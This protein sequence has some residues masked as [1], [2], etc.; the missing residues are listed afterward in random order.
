MK[1]AN[2]KR[3]NEKIMEIVQTKQALDMINA[4]V[5]NEIANSSL[6]QEAIEPTIAEAIEQRK[7]MDNNNGKDYSVEK[8]A[9][10]LAIET[11]I[12]ITIPVDTKILDFYMNCLAPESMVFDAEEFNNNP[13][14]KNID[15]HNKKQGNYELCYQ[16]YQPYEF[17]IYDIPK[18]ID[19]IH[20]DIPRIG[21]FKEEFEYPGIRQIDNER[22]WMSV[23]PNEV[24][25]VQPAIDNAKGKVLTL[26]CGMG[27]FAY[28]ASLKEEV[29]S[30]TIIELEQDVI[31]LFENSILPQFENK[32]KI[33]VIKAD[34]IDF[35]KDINDGEYDYC[36]AD[37]WIGIDH[38]EPYFA[39]KE[40][41]RH[42]RKTKVD[43]WMEDAFATLLTYNVWNEIIKSFSK[44]NNL[45]VSNPNPDPSE[46]DLRK[47]AF[48]HRLLK[49]V[50]INK[51]EDVDYY[52]TPK[53]LIKLINKSKLIF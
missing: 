40:V 33:K 43:Y 37:I 4:I 39:V 19:K 51:P 32:D 9:M 6:P 16:N 48:I 53:N 17:S 45:E 15:F 31:D 24:Y 18:H 25:T 46:T 8:I 11:L 41:C 3:I 52:L 7:Q 22:T 20:I 38:I 27:Y 14:I 42:L 2:T 12:R 21:C 50:E 5:T 36:F 35:M 28:M 13:Y 47:E 44:I 26:G 30:I 34:A 23:T 10:L 29:E 49:N 1:L